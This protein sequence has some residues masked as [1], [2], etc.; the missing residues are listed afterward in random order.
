MICE[1]NGAGGYKQDRPKYGELI[2]DLS[3]VSCNQFALRN[4][5]AF[6]V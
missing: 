2:D 4:L 5:L 1:T 6:P 3:E